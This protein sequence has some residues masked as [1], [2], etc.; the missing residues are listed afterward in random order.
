MSNTEHQ[1]RLTRQRSHR[2]PPSGETPARVWRLQ[3]GPCWCRGVPTESAS[4]DFVRL[5]TS[6]P[7]LGSFEG[8]VLIVSD[9]VIDGSQAVFRQVHD[10]V[11]PPRL[12]IAA[13]ACP[14]AAR[15]W[16]ELPVSWTPVHEVLSVDIDVDECITGNPEALMAAMVHHVLSDRRGAHAPEGHIREDIAVSLGG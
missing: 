12:V 16:D 13:K 4:F 8:N 10:R 7:D 1:D 14:A 2:G 11:A 5:T 15:F 9:R 3:Y 6:T